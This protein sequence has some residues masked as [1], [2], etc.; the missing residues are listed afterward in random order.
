MLVKRIKNN[1]SVT[2]VW[3]GQQILPG[4]YY[5]IVPEEELYFM[6]DSEFDTAVLSGE[7]VI[8]NGSSDLNPIEGLRWLKYIEESQ[9]TYFDNSGF[10]EGDPSNTYSASSVNEAIPEGRIWKLDSVPDVYVPSPEDRDSLTYDSSA[11]GWIPRRNAIDIEDDDVLVVT[12]A[13]ILNFDETMF[14]AD[15]GNGK[16]KIGVLFDEVDEELALVQVRRTTGFTF[17]LSWSDILFDTADYESDTTI[18]EWANVAAPA[19]INIKED[20][21][22]QIA[23]QFTA[24]ANGGADLYSRVEV[25]GEDELPGSK[26]LLQIGTDVLGSVFTAEL[27]EGDYITLQALRENGTESI[28]IADIT[29]YAIYLSG[30]R[31]KQGQTGIQGVTGIQ[32]LQGFTGLGATGL[33][34]PTGPAG[35]PQ[36]VTGIQGITGI[37]G[38]ILGRYQYRYSNQNT[39]IPGDGSDITIDY[40]LAG[41]VSTDIP[42]TYSAVDKDFTSN[43]EDT[44]IIDYKVT[45]NV[46][47]GTRTKYSSWMEVNTGSGWVEYVGSRQYHYSRT[48]SQGHSTISTSL[49]LENFEVGYKFRIRAEEQAG[50]SGTIIADGCSLNIFS[51]KSKGDKGAPGTPGNGTFQ[52]LWDSGTTYAQDDLVRYDGSLYV[53]LQDSNTN[54]TPPDNPP[55]EDSWWSLVVEKGGDPETSGIIQE[56]GVTK[57]TQV[58]TLN[59]QGMLVTPAGGTGIANMRNVFGSQFQDTERE[60]VATTTST[61]ET[62]LTL[63]AGVLPEGRYRVGWFYEWRYA[64]GSNDFLARVQWNGGNDF[65]DHQQEPQDVSTNIRQNNSGFKYIDISGGGSNTFT[66]DFGGSGSTAYMYRGRLEI[67]RVS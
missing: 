22:Y 50:S 39:T 62:Y 44:Y 66:L 42:F 34:G 13:T 54:N 40:N 46:D 6:N 27:A 65:F 20:G 63:S 8:N 51:I 18:L 49:T 17:P 36:G 52:G 15:Q 24:T 48:N 21:Y 56:D 7:A 47:D 10:Y 26:R 45:T 41:A 16:A 55:G 35:A 23:Y 29:M 64:S 9:K 58:D 53:S 3:V 38:A 1:D 11:G 33:L 14:V 4:E 5:Q 25:N 57:V 28:G 43:Y 12:N 67:W 30:A 31:G 32:G 60:T 37:S 59:F 19:R 61:Y 2:R